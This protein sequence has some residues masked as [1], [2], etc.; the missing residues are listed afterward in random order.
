M[1]A[2]DNEVPKKDFEFLYRAV[3]ENAPFPVYVK[4]K[5]LRFIDVNAAFETT[6]NTTQKDVLGRLAREHLTSEEAAPAVA[7]D[8]RVVETRR[9][10]AQI[11][12]IDG[13][14]Y[15]VYKSPI[16][17]DGDVQGI[18][19]YDLDITDLKN[20]EEQLLAS[21]LAEQHRS[22]ELDVARVAAEKA[23]Q[24]KSEFLA[25]M[26]HELRTPLNAILGFS[27]ALKLGA[28]DA[29]NIERQLEYA[30][31]I[32]TSG[33]H[34]LGL[35]DDLLDLAKVEAGKFELFEAELDLVEI[36]A[37][38][39]SLFSQR[40]DE[41][42]IR[43]EIVGTENVPKFSGDGRAMRQ[44]LLNL[45]SNAIKFTDIGGTIALAFEPDGTGGYAI[46][47][48]DTGRGM[49]ALE[50]VSALEEFG[51]ANYSSSA[52]SKGTGLGLPL[53]KSL[54]ELHEGVLSLTSV[55]GEGTTVRLVF[56]RNR[57]CANT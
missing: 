34:L 12:V 13:R 15:K 29:S 3:M 43:V 39:V 50:Q 10:S 53:A 8:R 37:S 24:V 49:S 20:A 40:A 26:S 44:V 2:E 14:T 36:A 25:V 54:V 28:V 46:S 11:E 48:K 33:Q 17:E 27:E 4:D 1:S 22:K 35:L 45:L 47:I 52:T 57:F 51:Q 5:N 38:V 23:N 18:V 32:H 30:E 19:G 55:P 6:F 31:I 16:L 56:G 9:P 41:K 7:H 21:Q 42:E